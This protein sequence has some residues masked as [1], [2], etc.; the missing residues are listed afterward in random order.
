[1]TSAVVFDVVSATAKNGGLL[2]P[3]LLNGF[4]FFSCV[5]TTISSSVIMTRQAMG[6]QALTL[7]H[8]TISNLLDVFITPALVLTYKSIYT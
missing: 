2:E 6:D 1:M 5:A 3:R 8:T 4:I 7:V